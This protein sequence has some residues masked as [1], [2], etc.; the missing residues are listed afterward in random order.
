MAIALSTAM[1]PILA[2]RAGTIPCHPMPPW[3]TPG[4]SWSLRGS[5]EASSRIPG[6]RMPWKRSGLNSMT[7]P[8]QL[9][10]HPTTPVKSGM[11]RNA[12]QLMPSR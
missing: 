9:I 4:T 6:I 2:A 10:A 8:D 1:L 3:R 11:V 7:R 12:Y 5:T